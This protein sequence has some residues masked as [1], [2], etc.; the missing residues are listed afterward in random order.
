MYPSNFKTMQEIDL[1]NRKLQNRV[2][3]LKEENKIYNI[4]ELY[5]NHNCLKRSDYIAVYPNGDKKLVRV[6]TDTG[7]IVTLQIL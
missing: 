4:P 2:R 6:S 5:R 7:K 3:E 1:L